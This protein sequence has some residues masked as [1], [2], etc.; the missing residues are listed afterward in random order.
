MLAANIRIILYICKCKIYLLIKKYYIMERVFSLHEDYFAKRGKR[1]RCLNSR[2]Y[3]FTNFRAARNFMNEL[4][5]CDVD[6]D[7]NVKVSTDNFEFVDDSRLALVCEFLR[8]H[9]MVTDG[10]SMYSYKIFERP[11]YER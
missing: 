10:N 1:M 9:R 5:T 3:M 6:R 11:L 4:V 8:C 2:V 7:Y